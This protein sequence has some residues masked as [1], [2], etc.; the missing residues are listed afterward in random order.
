MHPLRGERL[1]IVSNGAAPAAMALDELLGRNGK[2]A[3]LGEESLTQLG[4][5]LPESIRA[6]NP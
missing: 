5:V 4:E 2:L 6:G 3:Q 1:M